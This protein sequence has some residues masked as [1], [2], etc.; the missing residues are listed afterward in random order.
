M[1]PRAAWRLARLLARLA[2]HVLHAHDA[3]ALQVARWARRL[4][5]RRAGR[6][7]LVVTRRV[8][9]PLRRPGAWSSADQVIAISEAVRR[10]LL[11]SDVPAER[12]RVIPSGVDPDE[13]RAAAGAPLD[14]RGR[15]GL[16]AGT[17]LAVHL[18]ALVPHKDQETLVRAAAAAQAARPDLHWAI[19]GEGPRRAALEH[20]IAQLGLA[21]RVHLLGYIDAAD[22]LI[23]EA[24]VLVMSS[25]EEGLGSVVLQALA[26]GTPVVATR[27]GGLAEIVAAP[28]LVDVGDAAALGARVVAA[29]AE[30]PAVSLP[31]RYTARA[32]A[33]AVVAT[34][35]AVT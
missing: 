4:A 25:R 5:P 20:A 23:R 33:D 34:Y 8:D 22:A 14:I 27:A 7:A 1:D 13:V 19:A 11:A 18:A 35:R 15:L 29:V 24:N 16:P 21:S 6:P 12:I 10:V 3:H 28:W 26:L 9:F 32:V 30:R 2:P 17:P 31:E